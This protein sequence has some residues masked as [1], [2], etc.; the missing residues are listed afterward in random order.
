MGALPGHE[1]TVVSM[2]FSPKGDEYLATAGKDRTL[3]IHVSTSFISSSASSSSSS[4]LS[5]G[6]SGGNSDSVNSGGSSSGGTGGGNISGGNGGGNGTNI[7]HPHG[8]SP[9]RHAVSVPAAH[10]RIIW[11]SD[12]TILH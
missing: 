9:Y 1:S 2:G 6:E 11:V 8:Q 4:L 12:S 5:G 10:K 3:C 7:S